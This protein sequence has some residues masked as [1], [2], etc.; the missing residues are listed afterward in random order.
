MRINVGE[1]SG[2]GFLIKH[3]T[4]VYVVTAKHVLFKNNTASLIANEARI[5]CYP[6]IENR[7]ATTPRIYRLDLEVLTST[8][9]LK[10]HA[11]RDLVVIKIGSISVVDGNQSLNFLSSVTVIQQSAGGLVH[12]DMIASR[13]FADVE[14]TNEVFVLGYPISLSTPQ[15]RQIDYDAPLVRKGI[16]AGK[17]NQTQNII[18]DCPVYGGNSGGL[19]LEI[20]EQ[21]IHLIGIVVQFIPFV[22]Q[23]TN[24]RFPELQNTNLQNSGYSVAIPV[25]YIYELISDIEADN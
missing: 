5:I 15:M 1:S 12:Y 13:R 7:V 9:D 6:L 10:V 20:N 14:V 2:S 8:G 19:V 21:S 18:L 25:D 3:G 17:N 11:T 22:E 16:V 24:T 4:D 23:W